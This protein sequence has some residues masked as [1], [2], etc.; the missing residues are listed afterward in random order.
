MLRRW[1]FVLVLGTKLGL[2]GR[3]T[4]LVG[5][6][7]LEGSEISNSGYIESFLFYWLIFEIVICTI[8]GYA[9]C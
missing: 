7:H 8:A 1:V 2:I 9:H 5:S 3:L 6:E 4:V